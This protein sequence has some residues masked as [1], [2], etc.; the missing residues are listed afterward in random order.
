M[1]VVVMCLSVAW[2][3][4]NGEI[5]KLVW[6]HPPPRCNARKIFCDVI[7][8]VF[9]CGNNDGGRLGHGGVTACS[10]VK[11][12]PSLGKDWH[13]CVVDVACG[14][15]YSAAVTDKG[16]WRRCVRSINVTCIT[17]SAPPFVDI[18]EDFSSAFFE[19]YSQRSTT[20][21]FSGELYTW[22]CGNYGRLGHNNSEDQLTPT[23]VNALKDEHVVGVSCGTGDAHT[24]AVTNDGKVC[25]FS[26]K[27]WV[28]YFWT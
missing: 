27:R 18:T 11:R 19:I 3:C 4:S 25:L 2:N 5:S 9:S 7:G 24:M 28:D 17:R 10:T 16:Q 12:I 15:N 1:F 26:Y 21:S 20:L 13:R 14:S 6:F 23:L 8:C 22:G